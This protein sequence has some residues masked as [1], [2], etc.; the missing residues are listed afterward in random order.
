[1]DPN[2]QPCSLTDRVDKRPVRSRA[3]IALI[4]SAFFENSICPFLC[5]FLMPPAVRPLRRYDRSDGTTAPT[6][7]PLRRYDRSGGTTAPTAIPLR[8][9]DSPDCRTAPRVRRPR[10][11]PGLVPSQDIIPEVD[12]TPG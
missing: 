7:R 8:R 10:R 1:M 4:S 6:V 2:G 12:S 9:Y 11:L 3:S 5:S